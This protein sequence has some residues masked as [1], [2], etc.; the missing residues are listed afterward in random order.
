LSAVPNGAE[1]TQKLMA[2]LKRRGNAA[3]KAGSFFESETLYSKALEH[4][5]TSDPAL[6]GNRSAARIGMKKYAE[7]LADADQAVKLGFTKGHFRRG[8]ALA[9]LNKW[10]E[11]QKAY[12]TC[13]SVDAA[14]KD[15]SKEAEKAK[16]KADEQE[17]NMDVV[18]EDKS[19][20][21]KKASS[22]GAKAEA[23]SEVKKKTSKDDNKVAVAE[24]GETL[25]ASKMR[26]YKTLD[27]GR[28][29]TYFHMD[30]DPEQKAKLAAENKPKAITSPVEAPAANS[31][32]GSVWNAAGTFEERDM[33]KWAQDKIRELVRGVS[34][35]FEGSGDSSGI[36]E[37][38]NVS[39]FDGVASV[40]FIRGSR[41]YPFDFT[42]NV[43]W[44]ASIS[45]GEFSGRLFFSQFTSDDEDFEAEVKWENRDKAGKNAKA[46]FDHIKKDFR[47]EV[48]GKL[49]KFIEEFRKL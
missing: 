38:T 20:A 32:E 4:D 21:P 30:I 14:N 8:Q 47:T 31:K 11:A 37:A 41:R 18:I 36:V 40:S 9:G 16:A 2:E 15:A 23:S 26:G 17:D 22:S 1:D 46:L 34:T 35:V 42:F 24:D 44:T 43:D 39:D 28:K 49:R 48:D 10:R 3:F 45:E 19:P 6:W 33:T 25:D 29:T 12:E 13:A 7:A 27:D 5:A